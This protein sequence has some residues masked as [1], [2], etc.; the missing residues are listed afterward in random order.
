MVRE[1]DYRSEGWVFIS[2]KVLLD[3]IFQLNICLQV[4]F[5]KTSLDSAGNLA[6]PWWLSGYAWALE[7]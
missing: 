6:R 5:I 4:E 7:S 3:E 2:P 1:Y